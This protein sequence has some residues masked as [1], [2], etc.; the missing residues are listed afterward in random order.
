[1]KIQCTEG[2]PELGNFKTDFF[3]YFTC[4]KHKV[5]SFT[6]YCLKTLQQGKSS[7]KEY[8]ISQYKLQLDQNSRYQFLALS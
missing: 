7:D 5:Q 4:R 6:V 1:M 3:F 2:Q 8:K